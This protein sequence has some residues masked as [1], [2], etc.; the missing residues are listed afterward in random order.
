MEIEQEENQ[1]IAFFTEY[2]DLGFNK[3]RIQSLIQKRNTRF[4]V[5]LDEMREF[6]RPYWMRLI[7]SPFTLI[8][9]FE[10]A[11]TN[12]VKSLSSEDQLKEMNDEEFHVGFIGALPQHTLNP[13][14]LL[15]HH[16]G[17]IIIIE[18]IITRTSLVRPKVRRS[19]HYCPNSNSFYQKE[20]HDSTMIGNENRRGSQSL[21]PLDDGEGNPLETEYG[22]CKYIDYQT[23]SLQEMPEESPPG[24]L[25]RSVEIV[26]HN[27]LVDVVKAGD[28][29]KI[30]GVY[31]SMGGGMK[32]SNTPVFRSVIVANNIISLSKNVALSNITESDISTIKKIGKRKNV[33]DFLSKSLAPSIYGHSLIKK[34]VL[35]QLLGG[36]E[37]NLENGTHLRGDINILMVGD[38]STAKSQ[39]LRFVLKMAPLAIATT[40]RGSSGVGLTAAITTDKDTG[41]RKLEAG[42]MVLADRGI[43]C[44]DE[45]DKMSDM[46]RV[47]IHEVMEQQTVTIAKAGIHTSLNARCS[48]IAASNPIYGQYDDKLSPSANTAL[49]DSLMSRFDLVFIVL[50]EINPSLDRLIANHVLKI[51]R[52]VPVGIEEGEPISEVLGNINLSDDTNHDNEESSPYEHTHPSAGL[53]SEKIL[54]ISFLKK[55]INYA[56]TRIKPQLTEAAG[57]LLIEFYA[58]FRAKANSLSDKKSKVFPVTPRTLESLIRLA[59]AHAKARLSPKIEKKDAEAAA[60]LVKYSIFREVKKR[61]ETHPNKKSKKEESSE[62]EEE[63]DKRDNVDLETVPVRESKTPS[64]SRSVSGESQG[65]VSLLMENSTVIDS[66]TA[67]GTA[68]GS[69][70]TISTV[71]MERTNEFR[72]LLHQVRLLHC[73][74]VSSIDTGKLL[75]EVNTLA[76]NKF[77][78]EEMNIILKIMEEANQLMVADDVAYFV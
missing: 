12:V 67:S 8:P 23:L 16:L 33:V 42:A 15:A 51:H 72:T 53:K 74:G 2:L 4:I 60:E 52:Y 58:E 5:N 20:Y 13:R 24:Q 21:Y 41:E 71:T 47:A 31:R 45:F 40:G 57:E 66:E 9:P 22:F 27:D 30:Y 68:T 69:L 17:K 37:K 44:I 36:A 76:S 32:A 43:V 46:D 7:N 19:V 61:F 26:L 59:T 10:N 49:P 77:S 75:K 1:L 34:A 73:V 38:P 6:S 65:G 48:V 39:L 18:G 11:L 28:R 64:S 55:Y 54:K 50:D 35:L 62:E 29:V 3:N 78:E 25:P 70:K 63:E 14:T 56:K